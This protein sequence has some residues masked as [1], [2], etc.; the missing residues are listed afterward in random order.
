[1]L[2]FLTKL[3]NS[4]WPQVTMSSAPSCVL[5]NSNLYQASTFFQAS[6]CILLTPPLMLTCNFDPY[7]LQPASPLHSPHT[8]ASVY[9][10]ISSSVYTYTIHTPA[11]PLHSPYTPAS[12]HAIITI[13]CIYTCTPH[14]HSTLSCIR[15]C[16]PHTHSTLSPAST[17]AHHSP[18]SP[19]STHHSLLPIMCSHPAPPL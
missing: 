10:I 6:S 2:P 7:S 11:S 5:L 4:C 3:Y 12:T 15:T 17:H 8:P 16:T 9:I 14:T 18:C 1:M 19:A 13:S